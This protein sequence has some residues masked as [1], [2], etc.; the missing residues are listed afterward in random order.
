MYSVAKRIGIICLLIGLVLCDTNYRLNTPIKPSSYQITISPNF[1]SNNS[2]A[3]TFDGEVTIRFVT[4]ETTNQIKLHSTDLNF[5]TADITLS[6]A[7]S[8]SEAN[9]LVFNQTYDFVY[10]NLASNL[11]VN[12]EYS[13]KITY[14]G[15]IR[16]DLNGF[17]G[18]SYMEKGEKKWVGA[19]QM[20]PTHA[21]KAFPCF[22]EPQLKATFTLA[23]DR[24]SVYTTLSNMKLQTTTDLENG[25]KRD[26]YYPTPIMSTYLVAFVVSQF[27]FA[28]QTSN[29]NRSLAIYIRPEATNQTTYTYDFAVKAVNQL[30]DYLG[31]DYFST[32]QQLKLDHIGLPDFRAGA[33]E[34]WGLVTYRESLFVYVPE[35]SLP[36]Y[37]YRVAQIISHETTHMWFGN[38]VTCHWWSDTWL[39]EGFANYFQ[40]YITYLIEPE[41]RSDNLL[42]TGSVYNAYNADDSAS[43]P[44][45]SYE[46]V[47]TPAEI[48][49][50]FGTITYQKGG[51]IIRM[52]HHLIGDEAFKTGLNIY[53]NSVKLNSGYP[54]RLYEG[55]DS[56][57]QRYNSLATYPGVTIKDI[58][59]SWINQAG[60]PIL[61]VN[62]NYENGTVSLSQRRFYINSTV[63]SNEVYKIPITYTTKNKLDFNNTKPVFVMEN[64]SADIELNITEESW[65]LFN[66]QE[67]GFYRVNY[68]D[69]SWTKIANAL[70]GEDRT[71]IHNLNRAKIV[72]DLFAFYNAD[73]VSFKRLY[74][75]LDFLKSETDYSVWVAALAGLKK[76]RS[77]YLGTDALHDIDVYSL[78]LVENVINKLGYHPRQS[79]DFETLRARLELLEFACD[80]GH[81]ECV[82]NSVDIFNALRQNN[83]EVPA[84]LR[85]L[86]YCNGLR[87][88]NGDDFDF[89]W[90]RMLTT[91]LAN[92]ERTIIEILGCTSDKDKLKS[93]LLSVLE[94]DRK[95]K[96][97]DITTPL[98]SILKTYSNLDTVLE[99]FNCSQWREGYTTLDAVVTAIGSSLRSD[100]DFERFENLLR[101]TNCLENEVVS[102]NKAIVSTRAALKWAEEH[103]SEVLEQ[104]RN[105]GISILP[106]HILLTAVTALAIIFV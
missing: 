82:K 70:K 65:V 95:I 19:T 11:A 101:S 102:A 16:T 31:I 25:Y 86:V 98:T 83:E 80:L 66:I 89:L 36:Y 44:P 62:V 12:V 73:E 79:D 42:V 63:R 20:E 29:S 55:L 32:D 48:S 24:P 39:N 52:I 97:Q 5:T 96:V 35:E 34:N 40:D 1:N 72:N 27:S 9:A 94:T 54:D 90:N 26:L 7:V 18:S 33:M 53:L 69:A 93:Y 37:K 46:N 85:S 75:V 45:I 17:Y 57:I 77:Q 21:R 30:S 99:N 78:G 56:G 8:F 84:S 64:I 87:H 106:S 92:E 58:M 68:D 15:P 81:E 47:N 59:S 22:D 88:G 74:E 2:E 14:R 10:I 91:N 28:A 100:N 103:K 104:V 23:I 49:G 67:T 76:L 38:L 71:N 41:L 43:S 13:L 50:H 105:S 60:H 4:N 51:T 3:L 61:N 6:P